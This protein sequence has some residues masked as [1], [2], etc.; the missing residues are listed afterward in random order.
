MWRE[1]S[2][3]GCLALDTVRDLDADRL[4]AT[5]RGDPILARQ[6]ADQATPAYGSDGRAAGGSVANALHDGRAV[7]RGDG[8]MLG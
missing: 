3:S 2:P 8:S 5:R 7:E 1:S 6:S 4:A